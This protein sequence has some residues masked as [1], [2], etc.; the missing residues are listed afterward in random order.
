MLIVVGACK[1]RNSLTLPRF[2]Q[3]RNCV[4]AS[5]ETVILRS[6]RGIKATEDFG[7]RTKN[8]QP[9]TI[10]NSEITATFG[11]KLDF[12]L[13]IFSLGECLLARWCNGSTSDSESLCHGSNPC[14]AAN[15]H[16]RFQICELRFSLAL[17]DN[18]VCF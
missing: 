11:T 15:F 17:P 16:L 9:A 1:S 5:P 4:P 12:G 8:R 13:L 3:Q 2:N 14:R 6:H 10:A 18:L 7:R